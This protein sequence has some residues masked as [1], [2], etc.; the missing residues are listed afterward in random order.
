MTSY[1]N[2]PW[3][4][5]SHVRLV[6]A[7]YLQ[8]RALDALLSMSAADVGK[9]VRRLRDDELK[10]V[11][12]ALALG[13]NPNLEKAFDEASK[14]CSRWFGGRRGASAKAT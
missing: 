14:R 13:R 4:E 5:L 1:E 9:V 10:H 12:H 8:R 7:A 6:A 2:D 11:L 3:R